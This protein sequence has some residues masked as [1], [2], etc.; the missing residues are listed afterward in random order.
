MAGRIVERLI[1]LPRGYRSEEA[2]SFLAQFDALSGSLWQ[3][4][5]GITAAELAW[6]PRR[7][8]NTVGMLLAHLSIVEVYWILRATSGYTD[9]ALSA[10][11]GIGVDD[12]GMPVPADGGPPATLKGWTLADYRALERK[13]RAFA[14]R[15]ARAL[16]PADLERK[17]RAD[18]RNG[19][20]RRYN[21]R[22]TLYHLLEHYAGHY[23]QIL[24]LRHLYR[25]RRRRP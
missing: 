8:T 10:V 7:G 17:F 19:E 25:E 23:G 11:L 1:G 21:V 22:W 18:R 12:D 9:A 6:Q 2:A 24:L 15:R 4:L 14:R 5:A 16:A 3:D 13:A 20:R